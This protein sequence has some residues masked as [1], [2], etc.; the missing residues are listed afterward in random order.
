MS[1]DVM[2][3]GEAPVGLLVL[4]EDGELICKSEYHLDS[5]ACDCVIVET[6]EC[7]C[8]EGDKALCH[9]VTVK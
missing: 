9:P 8:G 5:G 7:Y 6:G 2:T 1:K 4:E 3:V